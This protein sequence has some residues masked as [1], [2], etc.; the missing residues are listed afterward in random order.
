M[1]SIDQK[2]R[3]GTCKAITNFEENWTLLKIGTVYYHT[4]SEFKEEFGPTDIKMLRYLCAYYSAEN[5][6][7]LQKIK[8]EKAKKALITFLTK[9]K[10]AIRASEEFKTN[11]F[12]GM[13]K[14]RGKQEKQRNQM[15]LGRRF[16]EMYS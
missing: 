3:I 2:I 4:L 12:K 14:Q 16:Q 11:T 7:E 1:D 8:D 5:P 9:R 6:V 13:I 15:R 10:D